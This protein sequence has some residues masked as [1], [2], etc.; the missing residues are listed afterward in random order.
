MP[1]TRNLIDS[2]FLGAVFN[3]E[4][5]DHQACLRVLQKPNTEFYI[6]EVTLSEVAFLINAHGGHEAVAEFLAAL[7]FYADRLLGL[8]TAEITLAHQIKLKY[9]QFDFVDCC[10]LAMVEQ[11]QISHVCT[12]DIRHFAQY[13]PQFTD[14]LI[15]LPL[16]DAT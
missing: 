12:L 1:K 9:P 6:P 3:P 14:H 13:R 11:R 7:H 16:M 8:T 2:G 4:D 15:L 10:V 5:T